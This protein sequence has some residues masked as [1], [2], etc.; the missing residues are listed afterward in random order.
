MRFERLIRV[1]WWFLATLSLI[2]LSAAFAGG[3]WAKKRGAAIRVKMER[4]SAP[5]FAFSELEVQDPA[6]SEAAFGAQVVEAGVATILDDTIGGDG[7]VGVFLPLADPDATVAPDPV[8]VGIILTEPLRDDWRDWIEPFLTGEGPLGP[9]LS[10]EGEVALSHDEAEHVAG[11]SKDVI[12]VDPYRDGRQA[13]LERN[14]GLLGWGTL[15]FWGI[16]VFFAAMAGA[17]YFASR[18]EGT[19]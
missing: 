10:L 9:L 6:Y 4:P 2:F 1:P 3:D 17:R 16:G 13:E 5:V 14:L 7:E 12:W 19:R 8:T 11:V 15:P 18:D